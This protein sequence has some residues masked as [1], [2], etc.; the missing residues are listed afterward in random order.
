MSLRKLIPFRILA[1]I[2][3]AGLLAV[4]TLPVPSAERED[5]SPE[6]KQQIA[7]IEKQIKELTQKLEELKRTPVST[8]AGE[9][10]IPADWAKSLHWRP[11]GP[12]SMGGRIT[13]ISVSEKEPST[14]WIATA[15]GGL[16]KTSNNGTTF[17]HQFDREATVSIGDVCVS[18][19]NPAIVWVGTGE[20]NP[21]N[22]VSWGDGVYKSTDGGK[23]WKNMGLNRSFQIG[24]VVVHP[25]NPDIVYVGALGRLYGPSEERGLFKTTDGGKTW[26]KVKYIDDKTGVIDVIMHPTNPESLIIATWERQRDG[27]DSFRGDAKP[28]EAADVY[29]PSTVHAPGTGL[30]KTTDGGKTWKALSAGLPTVNKG[31]IGL[32][33]SRKDPSHVFAIIDTE[34][35]GTGLPP[36]TAY[37]GIQGDSVPEGA[38]LTAITTDGPAA[39]AGMKAGDV[40]TLFE[41]KEVKNYPA[42]LDLLRA[43]KPG[44]KVKVTYLRDK[45]KKEVEIA[46]TDRPGQQARPSLGIQIEEVEGGVRIVGVVEN[47]P[48]AKVGLKP[49]DVILK[50]DGNPVE[51]Q[52]SIFR[53][54]QGKKIGDSVKL[55]F[56]RDKETK[57]ID[58]KLEAVASAVPG[59]PYAG[60]YGGNRENVQDSQGPDGFQTGGVY[61]S[62]DGGDTWTR[63]NSVNPR[64]F[65]FSV[66]RVDPTDENYL[67]VCGVGMYRSSDG[68]KTFTTEG[69]NGGMHPDQHALWIDPRDGRHMIVGTDGG[70]Y[71]TYDRG[72]HWDF[73]A[74]VAIGQF[75]HVCIDSRRPYRAYGG[76]QDNGTWGGTTHSLAGSGPVNDDWI[77]V[78][79]GDGFVTRVD[80]TNPDIVYWE[81]QDG[82]LQRRNLKTDQWTGL[83][84][85]PPAG[86]SPARF[87]WNTPF[88]VSAHNPGIYY[89]AGNYVFRS[90]KGGTELKAISPEIT[91]TKRGTGTAMAESP[92]SPDVVW[93]GTDDGALQVTRD[94]GGKWTDVTSKLGAPGPRW[95]ASI[96][97]S[98]FKEGRAYVVLDAHRSNDDEPYVFMTEDFGETWKSLRNN[99]PVG[100]TRVLR[101]D[102][103]NEDLLYLGTEFA[104]WAS[105]DRGKT[106]SK[107]N[108]KLPTVAVHEFAQH[109]TA[110]EMV[111]ATHGRSLWV[112]DVTPLRQLTPKAAK[113][114]VTLY[115][116]ATATHWR[117]EPQRGTMYGA[118][119]KF[120]VGEN[121]A[122]GA[123]LWFSLGK[124]AEKASLKVVD[125]TGKTVR[126]LELKK[127]DL[128]A[129]LH[130]VGWDLR[131]SGVRQAIG[132]IVGMIGGNVG[133]GRGGPTAPAPPGMYRV[134][135]TVDGQEFTESVKVEADPVLGTSSLLADDEK[136]PAREKKNDPLHLD[137]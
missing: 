40:I 22:S 136:M 127:E 12:A 52:R 125:Y 30:Y 74:Q 4:W 65:Y 126:E 96:E 48:A 84:P 86:G 104:V 57:E 5:L 34:K 88:L 56:R 43:K 66:V 23:N 46:L 80:P 132:A 75:Y 50:I 83:R 113:A 41:G 42:L 29:A 119:S 77:V 26:N 70:F 102:L 39:K 124:K 134:V 28:P 111:A 55:T 92:K 68:G 121:P 51:N 69:I 54:F 72:A 99:L 24:K 27:F 61:K 130:H 79:G 63:I 91:K 129:G 76:L 18:P 82:N 103:E 10:G 135:L 17:E 93:V 21:R 115:K 78:G 109:P 8:P 101:E 32:C 95:V 107:I 100:S 118:G 120:F 60:Q 14:W 114:A 105:I 106:W 94:G 44:D 90:V 19:S 128:A 45:E 62:T 133:R 2:V 87:N 25:T 81:S 47:A 6:Q 116:P 73:H 98:R 37:I 59:R 85:R 20:A 31:R 53:A 16:L 35:S 11:I 67:F 15:S 89:A 33:W 110:G 97:A 58:V 71:S 49:G 36:P 122:Q 112:L 131:I 13:A 117:S 9:D 64:P 1:G 3:A 137:D 108:G 38:K 123:Q 7:D